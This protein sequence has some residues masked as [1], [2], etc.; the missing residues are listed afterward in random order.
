[1]RTGSYTATRPR[2]ND[3]ESVLARISA[4]AAERDADPHFPK[5]PFRELAALGITGIPAPDTDGAGRRASFTEEWRILRSV[6]EADSS[7]GRILD[8]HFN[9]VERLSVLAPEALRSTELE[10]IVKGG[11]L[12]GVWGA[13]PI[14]GEGAPARL[15]RRDQEMVIEGVKT[16]CSGSGRPGP[17]ASRRA[18]PGTQTARTSAPGVFGS[19]RGRGF[20]DR[21]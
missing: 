14:P 19:L 13:D 5:G 16:Y 10:A 18:R 3:L 9:A 21:P 11:L 7:V 8:G 1:M 20:G 6:S 2:Q 17:G 4:G 15:V 12:L